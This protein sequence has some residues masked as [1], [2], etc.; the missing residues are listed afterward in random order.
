MGLEF[1]FRLAALKQEVAGCDDV[2]RLRELVVS[3]VEL[4]ERQKETFQQILKK[5]WS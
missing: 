4:M 3:V 2:E 1:E 5:E